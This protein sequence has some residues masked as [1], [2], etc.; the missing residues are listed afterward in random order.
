MQCEDDSQEVDLKISPSGNIDKQF[1]LKNVRSV[2]NLDLPQQTLIYSELTEQYKH[3][4]GLPVKSYENIK[5][6]II[7]GLNNKNVAMLLKF[8]EGWL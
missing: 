6:K 3:L 8:K 1:Y 7:I 4:R 5:P 2:H